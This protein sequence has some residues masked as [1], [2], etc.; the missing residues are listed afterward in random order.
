LARKLGADIGLRLYAGGRL[1]SPFLH[2]TDAD[3]E[4]PADYFDR[5]ELVRSPRASAL[6]Y[7]FTHRPEDD[8]AL[9]RA[10][11]LYEISL[12]YYVLGLAYAGSPYAYH[13][14]GSTLAVDAAA[15]AKV[16]GFPK[17]TAGEDFY[18]LSKLAKVGAI[19]RMSGQP[20]AVRGRPS[21]RVPFGTGPA[22]RRIAETGPE[23]FTL[24]HPSLFEYLRAWLEALAGIAPGKGDSVELL[25]RRSCGR[26]GLDAERL[27]LAAETLGALDAV[28]RAASESK[29]HEGLKRRLSTWFD[30]FRTLKLLH[31]LQEKGLAKVVWD[32]AL[33]GASFTRQAVADATFAPDPPS[34]RD[35]VER[36]RALELLPTKAGASQNETRR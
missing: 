20:I 2:S 1:K 10:I 4:L 5:P 22:V 3:V 26:M 24:Y 32:E 15:Y 14:I 11:A 33:R 28:A 16:R 7:P 36:L 19:A 34:L 27:I 23:R 35:L 17:R 13:T 6:L 29:D 31:A 30:A 8:P 18:L 12:R 25:A 21:D 9:A